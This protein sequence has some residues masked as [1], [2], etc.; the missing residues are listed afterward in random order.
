M[1]KM[2]FIVD[3]SDTN[4]LMA[5]QVLELQFRVMTVPSGQKLFH[6]LEKFMPDLILLDIE[7]PEMD[8]FE[9]LEALKSN[10]DFSQIPVIFLTSIRDAKTEVRGLEMG[11]ID[12]ISKPFSGPVLL[13]RVRVH[14]EVDAIIRERTKQLENMHYNMM[15]VL[16]DI[17]ESRYE[18]L[19][20]R[21]WRISRYVKAL[22]DIMIENNVYAAEMEDIDD[23]VIE[24][25]TLLHDLGKISISDSILN[26]TEPLTPAEIETLKTHPIKGELIIEQM[27]AK[28]GNNKLLQNAKHFTAYHHENWD[29]TGYPNGLKGTNIPIQGRVMAIASYYDELVFGTPFR[30]GLTNEKAIEVMK[31]ESGT[32]FDPTI[33]A[34]F[35][36]AGEKFSQIKLSWEGGGDLEL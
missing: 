14:L 32:L 12:F 16:A 19:G 36:Q 33:A 5:K 8:G 11:I 10:K 7:M 17:I 6:L 25:S 27:I 4:L 3:D 29:G 28:T 24:G 26:K 13:N 23:R 18:Y 35:D 20:G 22:K 31:A 21:I 34:V 1:K 15:F 30:A 2:I 9:V